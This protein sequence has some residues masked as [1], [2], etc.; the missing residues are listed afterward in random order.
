MNLTA[1][2]KP[3][4]V[5]RQSSLENALIDIITEC[6]KTG[7]KFPTE[8]QL[9]KELGVSRTALRETLSSFEASGMIKSRQGSGRCVQ[10]PDVS[11]QI[12]DTWRI[13]LH[14]KPD[15]LLDFLEIRSMLEIGSLGKAMERADA[16]QLKHMDEQVRLM[17][18]K[19]ACGEAFVQEDREFH[20]ILFLST[21]NT[22]LE[23]LLTAFWDLFELSP[24]NKQHSNL[25]EVAEKHGRML[26]AFARKDLALMESLMKDLFA[27]ARYRIVVALNQLR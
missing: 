22:M 9:E 16:A 19:A 23:Q 2:H 10:I 7:E 1:S 15:M 4:G 26:E 8:A 5:P 6:L 21:G 11:V 17:K 27:D 25:V 14:V 20:K 13:L 18:D 12:V 24:L 3:L